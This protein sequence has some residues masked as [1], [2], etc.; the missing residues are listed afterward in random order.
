MGL[1]S[2]LKQ[3]IKKSGSSKGKMLFFPE[4][5]KVRVRFLN[6]VD[7]G[8][9]IPFHDSFAM[10]INVP[11][12]TIYDRECEY[13]EDEEL[14]HRDLYAWSVY[15]IEQNEVKILLSAA[16]AFSPLPALV[17]M[18]EEYG[19]L[20]DRDYIITKTGKGTSQSYSVVPSDKSKFR[21][22]KAKPFSE[23][24]LLELIDKAF[25][26]DNDDEDEEEKPK[27]K[28]DKAKNKKKPSKKE[29][30]YDEDDFE[31]D[32][33]DED[34]ELDYN[35]L[36]AKELYKLCIEREIDVKPKKKK[37]YYIEKLEAADNAEYEEDE[38]D[39]EEG[40]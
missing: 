8:F 34:E 5:E 19:T 32:E 26:A 25:P 12:Q 14:R 6:D 17:G 20:T 2:E 40:W 24:K 13:C 30:E 31:E 33:E 36:N 15:V 37:E 16:N 10:G 3:D 21:N 4:G 7:D 1:L 35:D 23:A 11:C 38:E 18:Y 29:E 9:K 28:K 27:K 22:K 39:E